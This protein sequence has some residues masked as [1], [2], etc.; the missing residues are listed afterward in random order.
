MIGKHLF[1]ITLIVT[2]FILS[3]CHPVETR[4]YPCKY[5]DLYLPNNLNVMKHVS[6]KAM[7]SIVIS[8]KGSVGFIMILCIPYTEKDL[9]EKCPIE[10]MKQEYKEIRNE[11]YIIDGREINGIKKYHTEETYVIDVYD[12]YKNVVFH[13]ILSGDS[14]SEKLFKRLLENIRFKISS[15]MVESARKDLN[16]IKNVIEE[17]DIP[18]YDNANDKKDIFCI[19]DIIRRV[20]YNVIVENE[21]LCIINYYDNYFKGIN[22]KRKTDDEDMGSWF[23]GNTFCTWVDSEDN[24]IARLLIMS[25]PCNEGH[26]LSKQEIYLDISPIIAGMDVGDQNGECE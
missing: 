18:F 17:L 7:D 14:N 6:N 23:D 4:Y 3:T 10:V 1:T 8:V 25:F 24:I 15:D 11:K 26:L 16:V 13:Y 2:Y 22:W 19:S 20:E 21:S 5:M 12:Y 9:T